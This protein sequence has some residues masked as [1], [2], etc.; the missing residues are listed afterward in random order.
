MKVV[1][2]VPGKEILKNPELIK[3]FAEAGFGVELQLTAEVLDSLTLKEFGKLRKMAGGAP[4]TV[5]APFIDMNPGALDS[6]V[7]EATRNR[8]FETT[9]TARVLDAEVIVFH[10]GYHPQ[11]IDPIYNTWFERAV[12]TFKEVS[13]EWRGKI[14]LE[15]VFDR[16]PENLK[17]LIENLPENVGVCLDVGHMNLF[18]DVSIPAWFESLGERIY[19]FHLHDNCGLADRHLPM[20]EGKINFQEIFKEIENLKQDYILNLEN[21]SYENVLKSFDYLRR[22]FKWKEKLSST[23]PTS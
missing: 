8:F 20:G 5:H 4:I 12:E 3:R 21:K 10:T 18:S 14:A 9:A 6:Y 13:K 11:K 22:N 17:M 23:L 19:E 16:T 7:L 1:A 2:H 15:N